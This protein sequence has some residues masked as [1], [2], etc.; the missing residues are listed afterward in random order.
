MN[1]REEFLPYAQ[2]SLTHREL[3]QGGEVPAV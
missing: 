3:E 1:V 2:P